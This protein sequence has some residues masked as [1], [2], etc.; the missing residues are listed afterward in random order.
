MRFRNIFFPRR[1]TEWDARR[2]RAEAYVGLNP[3][4][5]LAWAHRRTVDD[6]LAFAEAADLGGSASGQ[7]SPDRSRRPNQPGVVLV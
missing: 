3:Q 5:F 2:K 1:P 6:V 7:W 4:Q